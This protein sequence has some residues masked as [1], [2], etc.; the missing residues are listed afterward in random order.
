[1]AEAAQQRVQ[2]SMME[3]M[4]EIDKTKLRPIQKAMY[5]CNADCML[6]MGASMEEV[7][8]I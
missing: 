3:F 1:M 5:L 4:S 2:N 6:D 8:L 7:N